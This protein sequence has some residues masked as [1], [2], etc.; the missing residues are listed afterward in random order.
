MTTPRPAPADHRVPQAPAGGA[1]GIKADRDADSVWHAGERALQRAAGVAE[2]LAAFGP[3]VMRDF[4]P[5]QHRAFFAQLPLLF[6]GTLDDAGQPWASLL[7]GAPG[8]IAAPT[9]RLLAVHAGPLPGDPAATHWREGAPVGLLGLQAHTGRRNRMSGW[10]ESLSDGIAVRVGQS[11]GNCPK[12]IHPR[13]AVH[14]P[15]RAGEVRVHRGA[16]L[17]A[18]ASRL[19]AGADTF[20]IASAHPQAASTQKPS[21]GV[22]VS[23][24]GGMPGFVRVHGDR[25]V[26]PDY[27]GNTFFNTLGN[28]QLEPRCGL[29]F[30][31]PSSGTRLHLACTARLR[32]QAPDPVEWPGALRLLDLEVREAVRIE[33]GLPL[34]WE[35]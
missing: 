10:V 17:D 8:F 11:F 3:R 4:M 5:D 14:D 26:I 25:L 7:A 34:R 1:A 35:A 20:F 32:T 16:G 31:E 30:I 28:L 13:E 15:A 23:H 24:R 33:G 22:D 21:E 18:A 2:Q 12:Y 6:T 27:A 9:P 19:V 29:L